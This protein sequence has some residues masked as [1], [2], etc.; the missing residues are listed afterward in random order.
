MGSTLTREDPLEEGM[1]MFLPGESR[2]QRGLVGY[3]PWARKASDTTEV[4]EH[5]LQ[6]TSPLFVSVQLSSSPSLTLF[7]LLILFLVL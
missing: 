7:P 1:A 3:S 4:T 2:V 5:K 6:F